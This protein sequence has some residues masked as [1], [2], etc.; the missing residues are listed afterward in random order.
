[1]VGSVLGREGFG[2][3]VILSHL[4]MERE[5]TVA[6]FPTS[7]WF[8]LE[9]VHFHHFFDSKPKTKLSAAKVLFNVEAVNS[10]QSL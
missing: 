4:E 1:M 6:D 10:P 5:G 7:K 9:L 8:W 2:N 3:A